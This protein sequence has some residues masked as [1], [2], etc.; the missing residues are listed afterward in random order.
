MIVAEPSHFY[1]RG[2]I[3][4]LTRVTAKGCLPHITGPIQDWIE[5]VAKILVG[6]TDEEPDVCIVELGRTVG[7]IESALFAEVMHQFQFG[8]SYANFALIHVSF[9]R[10]K[11]FSGIRSTS[12][13]YGCKCKCSTPWRHRL[14]QA[15]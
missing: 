14:Y 4:K 7:S 13:K 12:Q 10:Y 15:K 1:A 5:H 11:K 9:M 2:G 3:S 6:E 8:D